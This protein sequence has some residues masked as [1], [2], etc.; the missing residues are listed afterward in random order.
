MAGAIGFVGGK[1]LE[2]RRRKIYPS[3]RAGATEYTEHYPYYSFPEIGHEIGHES[4]DDQ[5]DQFA[6]PPYSRVPTVIMISI[7]DDAGL[8]TCWDR[9]AVRVP[10]I[11]EVP[12]SLG[13]LIFG[14]GTPDSLN[15]AAE[16]VGQSEDVSAKTRASR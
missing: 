1:D 11:H 15:Q 2:A 14:S 3:G 8:G 9:A 6:T 7:A 16:T 4:D 12:I 10:S 5:F 13:C